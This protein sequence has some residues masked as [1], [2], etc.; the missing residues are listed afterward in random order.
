MIPKAIA[1]TAINIAQEFDSRGLYIEAQAGTPLA[2]LVNTS[3]NAEYAQALTPNEYTPDA[4]YIEMLSSSNQEVTTGQ[5]N[6]EMEAMIADI[7]KAVAG[8]LNF[9]KNVVKPL[10]IEL[11]AEVEKDIAAIPV[12]V[13][14]NLEVVIVS[15]PE[16]MVS[17]S[18]TELVNQFSTGE[19]MPIDTYMNLGDMSAPEVI[20]LMMT[21]SKDTDKA[22]VTWAAQL[23]DEFMTR[24]W[25]GVF[26]AKANADKFMNLIQNSDT[27]LDAGVAVLLITNKLYD[28][29]P[30]NTEM[31]LANFNNQIAQFRNQAAI[32]VSYGY[33]D[34]NRDIKLGTVIRK[35][36]RQQVYVNASTYNPWIEAGGINAVLFGSVMSPKP[37]RSAFDLNENKGEFTRL[38]EQNSRM[39]TTSANINRFIS[40]KNI[41]KMRTEQ[42][43]M[44]NL[45]AC[46]SHLNPDSTVPV[47][48][49]G[50]AYMQF[51]TNLESFLDASYEPDFKNLWTL[52]RRL[53]CCTVF[54]YTDCDKILVGIEEAT[55]TN[56]G[57]EVRE[58]VLLSTIKYVTDYICN[59][60]SVKSV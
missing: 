9:A 2:T 24:V 36:T 37:A 56:P 40:Y 46:F 5:H 58:A 17:S 59:Q 16:P 14:A 57:I 11:V 12:N 52:C 26:T 10:I 33:E 47:T 41:I 45:Q 51:K 32:R 50:T 49:D 6:L 3:C 18:F 54:Y 15:M 28:N 20:E 31:S 19:Y 60:M 48:L 44:A 7:S 35:Y 30:K 29:P 38:W 39:L 42:V 25:D 21:G 27:G 53:I 4:S 13:E 34:F 22:I 1:A 43:V 55:A 8:H 23:G